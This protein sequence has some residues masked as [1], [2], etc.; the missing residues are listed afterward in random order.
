[1]LF[2]LVNNT[3]IW[4]KQQVLM[5]KGDSQDSIKRNEENKWDSQ[6]SIKRNDGMEKRYLNIQSYNYEN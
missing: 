5:D 1:M 4:M 2:Y 6:D 3:R